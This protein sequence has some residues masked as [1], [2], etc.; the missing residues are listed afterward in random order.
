MNVVSILNK[1]HIED[2]DEEGNPKFVDTFYIVYCEDFTLQLKARYLNKMPGDKTIKIERNIEPYTITVYDM[3]VVDYEQQSEDADD[4][5][6]KETYF[7]MAM[8]QDQ[9]FIVDQFSKINKE[10]QNSW[11]ID[12]S[13]GFSSCWPNVTYKGVPN[14]RIG[15]YDEES[16]NCS[17]SYQVLFNAINRDEL[18]HL[19]MPK[20]VIS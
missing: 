16:E 18:I 19:E 7:W 14:Y 10:D 15:G 6:E 12:L 1:S 13:E 9:K 3:I 20:G 11:E 2:Y 17:K 4:E 5:G 8:I